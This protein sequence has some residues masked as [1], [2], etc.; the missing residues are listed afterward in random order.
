MLFFFLVWLGQI[1]I[2][3]ISSIIQA[4]FE[5]NIQPKMSEQIK[6]R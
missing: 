2:F 4:L 6:K 5:I 1:Y 3:M